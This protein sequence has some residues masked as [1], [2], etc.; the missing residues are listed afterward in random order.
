MESPTAE[1][2][3]RNFGG[4]VHEDAESNLL[5]SYD[6]DDDYGSGAIAAASLEPPRSRG[7]L[8]GFFGGGGLRGGVRFLLSRPVSGL[9][10]PRST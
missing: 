2:V 9:T 6:G 7:V 10:L 4:R 8:G 1:T 5:Y 3:A